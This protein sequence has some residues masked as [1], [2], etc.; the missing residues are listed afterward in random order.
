GA[1]IAVGF[2]AI[3]CEAFVAPGAAAVIAIAVV[4][5]RAVEKRVVVPG[6]RVVTP[7]ARGLGRLLR[8]GRAHVTL[9]GGMQVLGADGLGASLA[10]PGRG[11]AAVV[12]EEKAALFGAVAH[13]ARSFC[14]S[15]SFR[16]RR[17]I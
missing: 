9:M 16:E 2:R 6:A 3:V 7:A 4:I 17:M 14:W 15:W 8:A 12:I 1:A 13:L 11:I 10:G 5:D